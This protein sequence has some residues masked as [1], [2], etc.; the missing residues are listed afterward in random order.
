M[1]AFSRTPSTLNQGCTKVKY[2]VI[3]LDPI[4]REPVLVANEAVT[5]MLNEQF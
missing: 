3:V 2:V 5:F 1:R 4:A